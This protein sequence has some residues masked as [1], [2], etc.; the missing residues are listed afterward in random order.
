[1]AGGGGLSRKVSYDGEDMNNGGEGAPGNAPA[2]LEGSGNASTSSEAHISGE[3]AG[4]ERQ[5]A[6]FLLKTWNL[7][8]DPST[9]S[10]ISW[11]SDGTS[12]VV[13][14]AEQ[15]SKKVLPTAFKH[16]NF[17]SF[18]RQLNIYGFKKLTSTRHEFGHPLF[19][20]GNEAKLRKISR[21]SQMPSVSDGMRSENMWLKT[22]LQHYIAYYELVVRQVEKWGVSREALSH[23]IG[24]E[25]PAPEANMSLPLMV[26]QPVA[27]GS[28]PD[29]AKDESPATTT[30]SVKQASASE[31]LPT[32]S[33]L[34]DPQAVHVSLPGASPAEASRDYR[35]AMS[36]NGFTRPIQ[37]HLQ[38]AHD[39]TEGA[40]A[41][42]HQLQ[43][44]HAARL[45]AF[46]HANAMWNLQGLLDHQLH[47]T[48]QQ[49]H[50]DYTTDLK[51]TQVAQ[52][53]AQG[54]CMATPEHFPWAVAQQMP[55]SQ[56]SP[57]T[58]AGYPSTSLDAAAAAELKNKRRRSSPPL[59]AS[60]G[61]VFRRPE[62]PTV[63]KR[64]RMGVHED[65]EPAKASSCNEEVLP[66]S[67]SRAQ[68]LQAHQFSA[69][70]CKLTFPY[71]EVDLPRHY[72]L[73]SA[74]RAMEDSTTALTEQLKRYMTEIANAGVYPSLTAA[75]HA[76]ILQQLS[77]L[78]GHASASSGLAPGSCMPVSPKF[79]AASTPPEANEVV[80]F[81]V[82][83]DPSKPKF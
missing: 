67:A 81:G 75:N 55:S 63:G 82:R 45:Q 71:P 5:P 41:M 78:H 24:V 70:G 37:Q 43:I 61:S 21:S 80:L 72:D 48:S 39:T 20:R 14:N 58:P 76:L 35:L 1:M 69:S 47:K 50:H 74:G 32:P 31:S 9:D 42:Q 54:R 2:L 64:P 83:I 40:E 60:L 65:I 8:N 59:L 62:L 51:R 22:K 3:G 49:N 19:Q 33:V 4:S 52:A 57:A 17:S 66:S 56:G 27:G 25:L 29:T 11:S 7:V 34:H 13:W 73:S 79:A 18:V 15:F 44:A 6:P 16:S 38:V 68:M 46:A 26:G 53:M 77:R 30:V 23:Q 10:V 28:D 36:N 12:F